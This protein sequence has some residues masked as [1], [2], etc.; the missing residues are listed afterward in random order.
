MTETH[1][2]YTTSRPPVQRLT[3]T[4]TVD[5]DDD[6]VAQYLAERINANPPTLERGAN[7]L[8]LDYATLD[9]L[10][11]AVQPRH[12]RAQPS[13]AAGG[14]GGVD[15]FEAMYQERAWLRNFRLTATVGD[16]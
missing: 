14:N 16:V 3:V 2:P 8:A 7:S 4:L 13:A 12:P 5:L 1:T 15:A 9:F 11:E 10:L 6:A